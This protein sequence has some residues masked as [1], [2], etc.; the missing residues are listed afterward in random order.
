MKGSS[1]IPSVS[2]DGGS[3]NRWDHPGGSISFLLIYASPLVMLQGS[4]R[5]FLHVFC[6]HYQL[7]LGIWTRYK[8]LLIAKWNYLLILDAIFFTQEINVMMHTIN[9]NNFTTCVSIF[10]IPTTLIC[11][12]LFRTIS[13]F[14]LVYIFF[15]NRNPVFPIGSIKKIKNLDC[16]FDSHC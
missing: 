11:F 4:R 6:T 1:K 14:K 9:I 7:P 3:K 15:Y 8:N 10:W 5:S 2:L 16:R 13:Y 12:T